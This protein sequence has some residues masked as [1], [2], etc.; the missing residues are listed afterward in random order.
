MTFP[1]AM[2][3]QQES[4]VR[5]PLAV[6][7]RHRGVQVVEARSAAEAY[8]LAEVGRVDVVI[9]PQA[10]A[11]EEGVQLARRLRTMPGSP[12]LPLVMLSTVDTP[13]DAAVEAASAVV[14]A[15]CDVDELIAVLHRVV[16]REG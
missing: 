8:G 7:L 3:V 11:D 16:A 6:Q 10:F 4:D 2:L 14:P 1:V 15:T 13:T 12:N 5:T 9:V